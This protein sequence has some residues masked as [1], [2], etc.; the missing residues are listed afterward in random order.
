MDNKPEIIKIDKNDEIYPS[1]LLSIL[2]KKAPDALYLQGN[3]EL[4][5]LDGVG[6]CGSRKSTQKGLETAKDCADQAAKDGITVISGNAAGVDM[7][8]HY[9]S[10][11]S[12]GS[13]I[14]V[15]PEGINHF[16]IKKAL[17][18][19]WSWDKVL[20]VSQFNP[21]DIWKTYR[22]MTR[23]QVIIGLSKAMIVIE[24]GEKGGTMNAG[25]ETLKHNTPLYVAEYENM[26]ID[27]LG[28]KKLLELGGR[29]LARDKLTGRANMKKIFN[30]ISKNY[31]IY[32]KTEQLCLI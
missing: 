12:G 7:E 16:Y 30:T 20:V 9:Q 3:S 23:N 2:G 21:Q 31:S 22:A 29:R 25:L 14:I 18:S 26:S 8:A 13:T 32:E 1:R 27:A 28:N 11:Y 4:L 10:L 15:L 17:R 6:F 24:A 19:V 5:H